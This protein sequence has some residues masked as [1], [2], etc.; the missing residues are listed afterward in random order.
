MKYAY[1]KGPTSKFVIDEEQIPFKS[2]TDINY[3]V[4]ADLID[5][6]IAICSTDVLDHFRDQL[7]YTD[8]NDAYINSTFNSDVI[9]DL[10]LA[11]E[12][13]GPYYCA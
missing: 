1:L 12:V 5:C 7:D 4:R 6:D 8:L 9:D 3:H 10:I 2:V 13:K 11:Y